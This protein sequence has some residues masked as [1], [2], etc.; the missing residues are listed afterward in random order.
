VLADF[1]ASVRREAYHPEHVFPAKSDPATR[2]GG[3]TWT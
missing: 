3:V 1:L 2:Q